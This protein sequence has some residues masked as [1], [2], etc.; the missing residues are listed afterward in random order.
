MK[1]EKNE[2]RAERFR[3]SA[4]SIKQREGGMVKFLF[5]TTRP[6]EFAKEIAYVHSL[7]VLYSIELLVVYTRTKLVSSISA[8]TEKMTIAILIA[9]SAEELEGLICLKQ[10]FGSI[11][12]ILVLPDDLTETLQKAMLLNPLYFMT[13]QDNFSHFAS[14]FSELSNIY[15]RHFNSQSQRLMLDDAACAAM[16]I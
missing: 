14:A 16:T 7:S 4:C 12:T 15:V 1:N 2:C 11:T 3:L 6:K 10:Q 5:F 13:I 8:L 9:S